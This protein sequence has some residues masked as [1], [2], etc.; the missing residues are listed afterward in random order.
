MQILSEMPVTPGP[1]LVAFN[2][3]DCVAA[4][5]LTLAK[6]EYPLAVFISASQRLG[7]EALRQKLVQL[8]AY[9]GASFSAD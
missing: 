6:E 3:I 5:T 8:I 1:I 7:L 9:A 4:E 2:K